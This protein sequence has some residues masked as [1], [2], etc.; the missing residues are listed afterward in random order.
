MKDV[1]ELRIG[2]YILYKGNNAE[3]TGIQLKHIEARSFYRDA[4][5]PT[6]LENHSLRIEDCN[7]IPLT[8]ELFLKC[9]FV[10]NAVDDCFDRLN[11]RVRILGNSICAFIG[12]EVGFGKEWY[13]ANIEIK[14]LHQLQNL[15]FSLTGKELEVNL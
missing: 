7:P 4:K 12:V 1:R 3:I 13:D 8:V 10:Y 5:T 14:S 15:Y 9:G 11:L 2:N 6:G